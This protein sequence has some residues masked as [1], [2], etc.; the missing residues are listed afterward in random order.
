MRAHD[1]AIE[2]RDLP[3]ALEHQR[4]QDVRRRR[5][6]GAAEAGKPDAHSAIQMRVAY[7]RSG[8]RYCSATAR[9]RR[10]LVDWNDVDAGLVAVTT[11]HLLCFVRPIERFST[12]LD[13][14]AGVI[15]ANDQMA[16]AEVAMD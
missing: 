4:G 14:C 6:A 11:E 13:G 15:A 2:Q 16:R 1:V 9:I 5:F 7:W 8:K 12:G 10:D 3:S